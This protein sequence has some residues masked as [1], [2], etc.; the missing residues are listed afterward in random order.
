MRR[1]A[2]RREG[3][4]D[5]RVSGYRGA[6]APDPEPGVRPEAVRPWSNKEFWWKCPASADH[7]WPATVVTR[8]EAGG[9]GCPFCSGHR[10]CLS[11]CLAMLRPDLAKQWDHDA[12]GDLTP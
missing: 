7:E 12:N 9:T 3:E 2:R 10:A 8:T 5:G 1:S 6:V 11:N 4:S